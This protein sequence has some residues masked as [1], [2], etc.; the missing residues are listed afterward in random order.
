MLDGS[1]TESL[2][3][4]IN[5]FFAELTS[6]FVPLTPADVMDIEVDHR[7]IPSE[8]FVTPWEA[9]IALRG[10]KI[11][12]SPGPD[13]IPNIVLK[14]F[15]FELAPVVAHL[16]NSSLMEGYLPELF[17]CADVRPFNRK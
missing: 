14:W 3:R 13:G 1:T 10:D 17:K 8:F 2:W 11:R 5:K 16:Y 4:K 9:G 15:D 12:K 7:N 6:S